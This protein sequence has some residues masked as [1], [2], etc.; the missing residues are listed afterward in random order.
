VPPLHP[1]VD[2]DVGLLQPSNTVSPFEYFG[3]RARGHPTK[4]LKRALESPTL[5]HFKLIVGEN[6]ER[7]KREQRENKERTKREQRENK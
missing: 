2:A 1:S 5:D 4:A 6:K 3:E 7:T